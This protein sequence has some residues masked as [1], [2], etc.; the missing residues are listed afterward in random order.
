MIRQI[1]CKNFWFPTHDSSS[2]EHMFIKGL[3]RN[4]VVIFTK[5][6]EGTFSPSLKLE[7]LSRKIFIDT[8]LMHYF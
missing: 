3:K 5:F 6:E 1:N 8:W 4:F 7:C 2:T